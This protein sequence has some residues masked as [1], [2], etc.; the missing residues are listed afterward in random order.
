MNIEDGMVP[1]DEK[2][3]FRRKRERPGLLGLGLY[4]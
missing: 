3:F 4:V 1:K 2:I